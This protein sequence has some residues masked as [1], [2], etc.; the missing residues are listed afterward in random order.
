MWQVNRVK[1]TPQRTASL[2]VQAIKRTYRLDI[3]VAFLGLF[4]LIHFLPPLVP[5]YLRVR[6]VE[7]IRGMLFSLL[8]LS[9]AIASLSITFIVL[10]HNFYFRSLRRNAIAVVFKSGWVRFIVTAATGTTLFVFS[11]WFGASVPLDT[12][13]TTRVYLSGTL[14]LGMLFLQLP[15]LTIVLQDSLSLRTIKKLAAEISSDVIERFETPRTEVDETYAII[16]EYEDNPLIQLRDIAVEAVRGKD[17][18]IPQTVVGH[19]YDALIWPITADTPER[20]VEL[21][22]FAWTHL[23]ERVGITAIENDHT[24]NLE[25]VVRLIFRSTVHLCEIRRY[26]H[27]PPIAETL[28]VLLCAL[29]RKDGYDEYKEKAIET[30]LEFIALHLK[31]VNMTDDELPTRWYKKSNPEQGSKGP[32]VND[33]AR[34]YWYFITTKLVEQ[35]RNILELAI[36][37]VPAIPE[38]TLEWP[39]GSRFSLLLDEKGLTRHQQDDFLV[40]IYLD[41][42]HLLRDR[43]R[44]SRSKTGLFFVETLSRMIKDKRPIGR[45]AFSNFIQHLRAK[46]EGD[47]FIASMERQDL[48][49]LGEQ[50]AEKEPPNELMS[51]CMDAIIHE[52]IKYASE[53]ADQDAPQ[54][55]PFSSSMRYRL[56]RLYNVLEEKK[57]YSEILAKDRTR[58]LKLIHEVEA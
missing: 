16:E 56:K 46:S 50:I 4:G 37:A 6:E 53:E 26:M 20:E 22:V 19:C 29:L 23:C 5:D 39:I 27:H 12:A 25:V 41:A 43:I 24:R 32:I 38:R 14:V 3:L 57:S 44:K 11:S 47:V 15:L 58:I 49:T 9:V 18:T 33:P 34:T 30:Y 54:S 8:S 42:E 17:W 31:R 28:T 21:K 35:F 7:N 1:Q 2:V 55:D 13:D 40:H 45:M 10:I 51:G 48:F 36:G 52:G